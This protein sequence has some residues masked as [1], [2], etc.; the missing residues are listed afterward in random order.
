MAVDTD[1]FPPRYRGPERIGHGGMGDIYRATDETLGRDVAIKLLAE[2]YADDVHR[3]GI[4]RR[5]LAGGTAARARRGGAGPGRPLARAGGDRARRGACPGRRP[6]GRQAGEPAP[7][8][9]RQRPRCRLRDRDRR[10][11]RLADA[12][13]NDHRHGRL[14]VARAGAGPACDSG[15]RRV[16]ARRGRL[17]A[18]DGQTAVPER[19]DHSRGGGPRARADSVGVRAGSDAA[20][21]ARRRLRTRPRQGPGRPLREWRRVRAGARPSV[22]A[23]DRPAARIDAEAAVSP[24]ATAAPASAAA[25]DRRR[26]APPPRRGGRGARRAP[27]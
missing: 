13:G 12:D 26:A 7:R 15:E 8:R 20:T 19:F 23:A 4:P 1:M 9:R 2:R 21:R 18:A 22:R 10:G 11:A 14:P 24:R 6:P 17:R 3:H 5:R 25:P 27:A 16:R